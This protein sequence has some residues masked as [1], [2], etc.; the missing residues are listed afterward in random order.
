MARDALRLIHCGRFV[1]AKSIHTL[2]EAVALAKADI[3]TPIELAL[4]GMSGHS[5]ANYIAELRALAA[6]LPAGA[7]CQIVLDAPAEQLQRAMLS[8]DA[9]VLPSRHEGFGMPVVEAFSAGTPVVCSRIARS[10]ASVGY[11]T[12]MCSR[13][14]SS[15]ASG[16]G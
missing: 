8:A 2:L 9:L 1:P 14:R 7:S 3:A 4:Y 16:S 11:S 12:R 15:C 13:N 6:A 5:D 10:S